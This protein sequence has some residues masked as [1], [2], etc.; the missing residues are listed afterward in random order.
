MKINIETKMVAEA[1]KR[2]SKKGNSRS[3]MLKM[4][5]PLLSRETGEALAKAIEQNNVAQFKSIW[6]KIG[7]VA[8]SQLEKRRG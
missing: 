8:S 4:I 3:Q 5:M 2:K 7:G 1:A 6:T